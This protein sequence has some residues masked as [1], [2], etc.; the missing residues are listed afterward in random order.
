MRLTA[1]MLVTLLASL[2]AA[3]VA[4]AQ[5]AKRPFELADL[6]RQ[7]V[8]GNPQFSPDGQW[9]VYTVS[10]IDAER[11]KEQ[12]D[13]FMVRYDGS[14]Q[15]Q[16]TRTKDSES[17][18]S[19]S[20][21]G[22]YIAFIAA[23]SSDDDQDDG[24]DDDKQ[25]QVYLLDRSGGE[26][27][28]ATEVAGDVQSYAW[29]PDGKRLALIVHDPDPD[30]LSPEEAAKKKHK[31]PNPIVVDRYTTKRDYVGFLTHRRSHLYLFDLGTRQAELLTPGD[32]DEGQA[33][34]LPDGKTIIFTS[35]RGGAGGGDPDRDYNWDL[36]AIEA[37]AGSTPRALTSY[38]GEDGGDSGGEIA[39]SIDGA[40]IAYTRTNS[41]DLIDQFYEGPTLALVSPAGGEPRLLTEELD[42]HVRSPRFRADGKSVYFT[43]ED[44]RS[45][46]IARVARTGGKP[47]MLTPRGQ[48]VRAFDVARNGNIVAVITAPHQP[49]ELYAIEG[50]TRRALTHHNDAWVA[51]LTLGAVSEENYQAKD[52]TRIGAMV[53][54]PPGFVAGRRYPTLTWIHGGPVSQDQNAFDAEAQLFAASGYV[55]LQPNYRGS[56]GRGFR[57]S[58]AIGQDWG[59]LEV[60]DVLA[61][62]DGLVAQGIADPD[63]LVIGGWSYG[64]MTTNYTIAKDTR[65]KAAVSIAG[66]SNAFAGYGTDQYI[67]QYEHELGLPWENTELYLKVSNPFFEAEKIKTPTLFMCGEKD[68]NVP[69]IHSEQMFQALKS[70]GIETQLVIYPD[71]HHGIDA[72]SY[73]RD[74][75]GRTIAWY[76]R[77]LG[78]KPGPTQT[79]STSSR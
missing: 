70:L 28:A 76:D 3:E 29:S 42:R 4:G 44:D 45:V 17:S 20:P 21:D 48:V 51:S 47:E 58:R 32:Y 7:Q 59:N 40:T 73:R 79:A 61:A 9:V 13:L 35:K 55:V 74:L 60:S 1:A 33:V 16:L 78:R 15:V 75:F 22:R 68:W 72:P 77:L 67:I 54:R 43:Y 52:G 36:Y 62:V 56:S 14:Q 50:A 64:S 66:I 19:F 49:G 63:Q 65:F 23:R 41:V 26:A 12:S 69:L 34:W 46:Q 53:V 25:S 31:T 27:M 18:P 8:V 5:A 57:F 37:R 38:L 2:L 39:V 11:D 10:T 6:A 71:A 24:E 30:K